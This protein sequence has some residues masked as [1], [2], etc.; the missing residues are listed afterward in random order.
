[1]NPSGANRPTAWL[2]FLKKELGWAGLKASSK[3]AFY[4]KFLRTKNID[5]INSDNADNH[6]Y[7]NTLIIQRNENIKSLKK[8]VE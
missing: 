3:L 6:D 8:I 4:S 5:V 7:K 1:M 2:N